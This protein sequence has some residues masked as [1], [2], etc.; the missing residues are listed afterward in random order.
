M[1]FDTQNQQG[2]LG[3]V[4]A[5]RSGMDPNTAYTVYQ[6]IAQDQAS[7]I[8][9]RQQRL[10]GLAGLLMEAAS[11]GATRDQAALLA[12]AQ[13]GPAGPA[14]QNMINTYYPY[15]NIEEG[16]QEAVN[17]TQ[18]GPEPLPAAVASGAPPYGGESVSPVYAGPDPAAQMA[19]ETAAIQQQQA[20]SELQQTQVE[21][22]LPALWTNLAAD[23]SKKKAE[24]WTPEQFIQVISAAG[25]PYSTLVGNY[26]EDVQKVVNTVFFSGV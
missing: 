23:A 13:A 22:A 7:Q 19:Q 9:N 5:L 20:L 1:N 10:T 11:G 14:V 26:P 25:S 2:L 4:T 21:M 12:D 6:N 15:G 18:N 3:L 8:A 16:T 24:G 17:F